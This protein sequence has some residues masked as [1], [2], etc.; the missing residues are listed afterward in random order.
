MH[1]PYASTLKPMGGMVSQ[2][3][4][5]PGV[6]EQPLIFVVEDDID[7]A[8][9]ICHHLN[10]A[11][12]R[13]RWFSSA[14]GVIDEAIRNQPSVFLLDVMIPG[15]DGFELCGRIRGT[16]ALARTRIVF[17]T[18]KSSEADRVRGLETGGDDYIVKPFSPREVLARVRNVLRGASEPSRMLHIGDLE[19][20]G[21]AMTI[22]VRGKPVLTTTREFYL[23]EYL[24]RNAAR[25]FTRDQLLDAVW[26]E[27]SFVTQRSVD[28]YIRRLR[29]K[30]EA[31]PDNP[32]Y[33]KTIRGVGYRFDAP[34]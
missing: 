31:D 34:K 23:L 22:T 27:G 8:G 3:E 30:I 28:V 16:K 4:Y 21:D 19:I 9:L 18:A 20:D 32:T 24:A 25:V 2:S 26:S 10:G 7:I 17:L 14:S 29:E 15:C 33:L 13:T 11:G 5:L 6:V 1:S 12:Y